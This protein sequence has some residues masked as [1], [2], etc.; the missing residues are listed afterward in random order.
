M[1]NSRAQQRSKLRLRS[2]RLSFYHR[3]FHSRSTVTRGT[4]FFRQLGAHQATAI[5]A[6]GTVETNAR[7]GLLRTTSH[8]ISASFPA[9]AMLVYALVMT[10]FERR[11]VHHCTN[12]ITF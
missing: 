1:K 2:S 9:T 8:S 11:R 7:R 5:N 3:N 4:F 6:P 12:I 10:L